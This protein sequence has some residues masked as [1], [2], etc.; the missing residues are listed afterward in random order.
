[1]TTTVRI[2]STAHEI[3]KQESKAAGCSMQVVLEEAIELYRRR[4]FLAEINAAYARV[5]EDA[6]A[7]GEELEERGVWEATSGDGIADA[8]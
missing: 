1:M 3:L 7:W 6:R 5:R 4:R 8:E 2:S